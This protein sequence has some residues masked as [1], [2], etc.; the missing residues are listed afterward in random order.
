MRL[1][2]RHNSKGEILSVV[3]A[4]VFDASLAHPFAEP[5]EGEGV[6]EVEPDA[7]LEALD[8]HEIGEKY[9]VDLKKRELKK[10]SSRSRKRE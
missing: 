8:C 1:F 10:R 9:A 5:G 6:L 2:V 7:G 4:N 3:K